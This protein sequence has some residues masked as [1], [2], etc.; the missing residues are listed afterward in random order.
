MDVEERIRQARNLLDAGNEK[1]AS[2]ELT[3]AVVACDDGGQAMEIR[4]LADRGL[5]MAGRFGKARWREI[6]RLADIHAAKART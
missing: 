2:R 6:A 4:R 3:D 1:A 5:E